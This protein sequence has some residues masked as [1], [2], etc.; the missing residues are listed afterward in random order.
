MNKQPVSE[1][2]QIAEQRNSNSSSSSVLWG[3]RYQVKEV[4]RSV[5]FYLQQLGFK[6]DMQNLPAFGQVSIRLSQL[7]VI[8][9]RKH[10]P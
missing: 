1:L 10:R 4:S 8:R 3:V 2:A 6:L 9:C 7:T 5:A